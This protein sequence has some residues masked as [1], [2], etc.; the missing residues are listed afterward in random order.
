M[1]GAEVGW[2]EG[3]GEGVCFET[4]RPLPICGLLSVLMVM[5]VH[6]QPPHQD[7]LLSLEPKTPK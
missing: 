4:L 7:G 3:E 2:G 6:S 1:G 5:D